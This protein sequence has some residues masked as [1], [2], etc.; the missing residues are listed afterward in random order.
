MKRLHF[1]KDGKYYQAPFL[2]SDNGS[3]T[4][5]PIKTRRPIS[6]SEIDAN[7][8]P[9]TSMQKVQNL[10]SSNQNSSK[11]IQRTAGIHTAETANGK[12]VLGRQ[13]TPGFNENRKLLTIELCNTDPTN[14]HTTVLFDHHGFIGDKL[15]LGQLNAVVLV[16]GSFGAL[17]LAKMKQLTGA[18]PIDL[19]EL[20]ITSYGLTMSTAGDPLANGGAGQAGVITN[21]VDSGAFFTA[22]QIRDARAS[23]VNYSGKDDLIPFATDLTNASFRSNIRHL[24]TWRWQADALNGMPIVIPPSTCVSINTY[25]SAIGTIY[26]M[27]QKF[28]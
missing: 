21:R 1:E 27:K 11:M 26:G 24:K 28:L 7:G 23:V 5:Y 8:C 20:H 9:C 19:H 16:N 10:I 18:T 17:T 25:V 3:L 4:A 14:P 6:K 22:G 13:E 15:Q 2:V 12:V